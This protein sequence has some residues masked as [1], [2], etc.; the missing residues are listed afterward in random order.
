MMISVFFLIAAWCFNAAAGLHLLGDCAQPRAAVL[1]ALALVFGA[2]CYLAPSGPT[3]EFCALCASMSAAAIF[4]N[5][6]C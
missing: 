1:S 6:L 3:V 5:C 2:W 4:V